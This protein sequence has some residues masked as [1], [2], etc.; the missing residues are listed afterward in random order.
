MLEFSKELLLQSTPTNSAGGS[1]ARGKPAGAA[2]VCE[3]CGTGTAG[4]VMSGLGIHRISRATGLR[5]TALAFDLLMQ[6][7]ERLF[8]VLPN[9]S[10]CSTSVNSLL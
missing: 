10:S 7:V 4:T 2:S 1:E 5:R 8:A 3:T 9:R 6:F